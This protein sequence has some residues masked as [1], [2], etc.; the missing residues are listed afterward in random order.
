MVEAR[1]YA[2]ACVDALLRAGVNLPPGPPRWVA[3]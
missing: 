1:L 3:R 2:Q